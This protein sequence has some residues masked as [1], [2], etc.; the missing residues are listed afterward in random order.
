MKY[1]VIRT[2]FGVLPIQSGDL[3]VSDAGILSA[4]TG[5]G[6]LAI[7]EWQMV[8]ECS[9][10]EYETVEQMTRNHNE[11]A[12]LRAAEPGGQA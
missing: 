10:E 6:M 3:S 12:F 4:T 5:E 7:R 9:Q 1:Y 8:T 11:A 2:P